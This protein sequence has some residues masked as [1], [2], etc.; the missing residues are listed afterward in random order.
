MKTEDDHTDVANDLLYGARH[1]ATYL[2]LTRAQIYHA[3]E[4]GHLPTFTI[5]STICL[6]RSTMWRWLEARERAAEESRA[7][8]RRQAHKQLDTPGNAKKQ[9]TTTD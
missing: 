9:V 3:S 1:I 8:S 4:R 6:R 5:G 7:S 2:G